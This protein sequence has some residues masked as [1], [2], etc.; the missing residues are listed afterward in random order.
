MES[1]KI[2]ATCNKC[3]VHQKVGIDLLDGWHRCLE[4]GA[5][6]KIGRVA[7][8]EGMVY[9]K[10]QFVA[11][12]KVS[13]VN[14]TRNRLCDVIGTMVFLVYPVTYVLDRFGITF[15]PVRRYLLL[16]CMLGIP[17]VALFW[18]DNFR[19]EVICG[20][21]RVTL[22]RWVSFDVVRHWKKMLL[23][24]AEECRKSDSG[25]GE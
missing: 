19:L 24:A 5:R 25:S 11:L 3:A 17:L 7:L 14:I 2:I 18:R 23:S 10:D 6:T 1:V 4:C 20:D 16:W 12:D 9:T 13:A 8:I 21:K 22:L 15:E